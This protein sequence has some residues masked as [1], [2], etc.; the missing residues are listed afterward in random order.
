MRIHRFAVISGLGLILDVS[1]LATLAWQG[2][3]TFWA[4]LIGSMVGLTFCFAISQRRIFIHDRRFLTA[5]FIT[6]CLFQSALVPAASAFVHEVAG[7]LDGLSWLALLP[8]DGPGSPSRHALVSVMA[9]GLG[10]PITLYCNFLF[11]GW[12]FERRLSFL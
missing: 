3:P 1:V 10:V 6:Y 2:L 7:L 11:M 8:V 4:N 5:K 12:L 9:K